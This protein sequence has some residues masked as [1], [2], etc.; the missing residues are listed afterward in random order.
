MQHPGMPLQVAM[1]DAIRNN[2]TVGVKCEV[3]RLHMDF[4]NMALERRPRYLDCR[5][6]GYICI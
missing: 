5:F 3:E 6:Q 1:A 4:R 2:A